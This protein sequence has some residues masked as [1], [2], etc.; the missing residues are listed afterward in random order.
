MGNDRVTDK[1][2]DTPREEE[3]IRASE[4]LA[5]DSKPNGEVSI[6]PGD[7]SKYLVNQQKAGRNADDY[8]INTQYPNG[9]RMTRFEAK[10]VLTPGQSNGLEAPPGGSVVE[11]KNG[12]QVALNAD[13]QFVDKGA[14]PQGSQEGSKLVKDASGKV[15][16]TL[17]KDQTLHVKTARGEYTETPGGRVSFK[18]SGTV[19][20]LESLHQTGNVSRDKFEDYGLSGTATNTRFP[21]GIEWDRT[22]NRIQIPDGVGIPNS[23]RE[24]DAQGNLTKVTVRDSGGKL[25]YYQDAQGFHVP[26]ADGELT[27]T[28]DGRVTFKSNKPVVRQAALP[29]VEITSR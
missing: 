11:I 6:A 4:K 1:S 21:N 26:T 22:A 16:A 15:V 19:T 28:D 23:F 2:T 14:A 5:A 8:T 12:R 13:G 27:Q 29:P 10:G 3:S 9:V 17:D 24:T 25:L 20:N 18:P 7:L